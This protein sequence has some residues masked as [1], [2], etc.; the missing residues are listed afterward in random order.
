MSSNVSNNYY[1][2][3][4]ETYPCS[5][6]NPGAMQSQGT[7]NPQEDYSMVASSGIESSSSTSGLS[8]ERSSSTSTQSS[9]DSRE[10]AIAHRALSSLPSGN[11]TALFQKENISSVCVDCELEAALSIE[12]LVYLFMKMACGK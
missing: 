8:Q 7:S 5:S 4:T 6:S 11:K 1:D 9:T 2:N 12:V 3:F 10:T